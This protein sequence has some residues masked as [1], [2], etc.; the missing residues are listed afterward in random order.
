MKWKR[1]QAWPV[2]EHLK[3]MDGL[4]DARVNAR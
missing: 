1:I 3:G 4:V 2:W